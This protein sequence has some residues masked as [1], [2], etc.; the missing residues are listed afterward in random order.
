LGGNGKTHKFVLFIQ[1]LSVLGKHQAALMCMQNRSHS[2]NTACDNL[3]FSQAM[4]Q[5]QNT[6]VRIKQ[7]RINEKFNQL[8]V[9]VPLEHD[10]CIAATPR[11]LAGLHLQKKAEPMA[12]PFSVFSLYFISAY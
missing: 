12:L 8:S 5:V 3:T 1:C 10:A 4:K 11:V 6:L 2:N 9:L 7:T